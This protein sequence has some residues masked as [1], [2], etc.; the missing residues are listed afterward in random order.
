MH[1]LVPVYQFPDDLE[2]TSNAVAHEIGR[3]SCRVRV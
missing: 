1:I 3:A 2:P